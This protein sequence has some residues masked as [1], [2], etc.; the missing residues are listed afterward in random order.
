MPQRLAAVESTAVPFDKFDR[1]ANRPT[2][3]VL[4]VK[5][6]SSIL[7]HS[8]SRSLNDRSAGGLEHIFE[9]LPWKT[10]NVG[11]ILAAPQTDVPSVTNEYTSGSAWKLT[12]AVLAHMG[13]KTVL[14]SPAGRD[15]KA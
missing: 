4:R 6:H 7:G 15:S 11:A 14:G 2:F 5:E 3:F 13:T 1:L 10:F 8:A 9:G 12:A